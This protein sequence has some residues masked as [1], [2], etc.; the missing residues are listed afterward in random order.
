MNYKVKMAGWQHRHLHGAV[1]KVT[2]DRERSFASFVFC[3]Q[4]SLD[5]VVGRPQ[6]IHSAQDDIF[7]HFFNSPYTFTVLIFILPG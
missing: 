6:N 4:G 1:D 5:A 7:M 3:L 2:K